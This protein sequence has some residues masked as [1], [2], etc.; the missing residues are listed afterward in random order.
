MDKANFYQNIEANQDAIRARKF[1]NRARRYGAEYQ[2]EI[3]YEKVDGSQGS[4]MFVSSEV[5]R[6]AAIAE[7]LNSRLVVSAW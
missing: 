7:F 4:E 2:H 6:S 1:G 5:N 3:H